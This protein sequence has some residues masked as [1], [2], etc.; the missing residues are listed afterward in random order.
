[1]IVVVTRRP[2]VIMPPAPPEVTAKR[3]SPDNAFYMLEE[4]VRLIPPRPG[5]LSCR[6]RNSKARLPCSR[7][8]TAARSSSSP[9]SYIPVHMTDFRTPCSN[10][11]RNTWIM[12]QTTRTPAKRFGMRP[13]TA[14]TSSQPTMTRQRHVGALSSVPSFTP[15]PKTDEP[16]Y[17][18]EPRR[19]ENRHFR[20]PQYSC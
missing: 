7:P 8:D 20:K 14:I 4:A 9:S 5:A 17:L 1:M 10:W 12:P 2:I 15:H 11:S 13:K 19:D 16:R 3:R 18:G 6:T